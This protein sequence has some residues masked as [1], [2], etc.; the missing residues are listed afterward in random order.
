MG[1]VTTLSLALMVPSRRKRRAHWVD[2]VIEC[3]EVSQGRGSA[4]AGPSAWAVL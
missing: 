3:H 4:A 2:G 1:I